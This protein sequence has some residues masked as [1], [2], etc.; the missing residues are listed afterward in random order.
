MHDHGTSEH[1]FRY[2][3]IELLGTTLKELLRGLS[4]TRLTLKS[5]V[6]V[7]LQLIDRLE[8]VHEC[9]YVHLDIKPDNILL[10]SSN[11]KHIS[12]SEICLIDFGIAQQWRNEDGSHVTQ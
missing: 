3:V 12:S 4:N 10:A 2:L 9:G 8:S 11:Y 6:Q 5:T 7:G 1:G